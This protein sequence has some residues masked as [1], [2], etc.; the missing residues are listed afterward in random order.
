MIR[1]LNMQ[2]A[3][4]SLKTFSNIGMDAVIIP[5][6]TFYTEKGTAVKLENIIAFEVEVNETGNARIKTLDEENRIWL[7]IV[8]KRLLDSAKEEPTLMKSGVIYGEP[9]KLD[10]DIRKYTYENGET[11]QYENIVELMVNEDDGHRLKIKTDN[12]ER[13]ISDIPKDWIL[14]SIL[15]SKK[16]DWTV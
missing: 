14:I 9:I 4:N 12:G 7:N 11:L 15:A 10:E 3:S 16:N 1:E 8:P 2:D 13:I 6:K 5:E